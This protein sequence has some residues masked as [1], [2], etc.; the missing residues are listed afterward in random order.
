MGT[1]IGMKISKYIYIMG[2]GIL[3]LAPITIACEEFNFE[4]SFG[5]GWNFSYQGAC[6]LDKKQSYGGTQSLML[7]PPNSTSSFASRHVVGP[8]RMDFWWKRDFDPSLEL[9]VY[10]NKNTIYMVYDSKAWNYNWGFESIE[11]DK[12]NYILT[13]EYKLKNASQKGN[14]VS[15]AWIDDLKICMIENQ[16]NENGFDEKQSEE[17]EAPVAKKTPAAR[18]KKETEMQTD[19]KETPNED[20]QQEADGLVGT[21]V[22][23]E[24]VVDSSLRTNYPNLH[25]WVKLEDGLADSYKSNISKI[26]IKRGEYYINNPVNIT[27]YVVLNGEGKN[28]TI[29]R[30]LSTSGNEPDGFHINVNDS[31]IKDIGFLDFDVALNITGINN[32]ITGNK[33]EVLGFGIKLCNTKKINISENCFSPIDSEEGNTGIFIKNCSIV[34]ITNNIFLGTNAIGLKNSSRIEIKQNRYNIS[35]GF[36]TKLSNCSDIREIDNYRSDYLGLI[37]AC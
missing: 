13:F 29:L 7:I 34:N 31:I 12:G 27:S 20:E 18:E 14:K 23:S 16:T 35:D 6:S 2:L 33:F 8:A 11:V 37:N 25:K 10:D 28:R 21:N 1:F 5:Q 15:P 26:L 36:I 3:L 24:I 30:P 9:V 4:N 22:Q 32:T 17:K 19:V